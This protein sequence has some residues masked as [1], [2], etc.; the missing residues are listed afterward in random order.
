MPR[1]ALFV[2]APLAFGALALGSL[3]FAACRPATPDAPAATSSTASPSAQAPRLRHDA[4]LDSLFGGVPGT[5]VVLDPARA[6]TLR[7]DA[8]RARTRRIP[9]STHKIVHTLIAL[10]TGV[11]P[12]TALAIR[13]DAARDPAEPWWPA[14]WAQDQTLGTAFRASAVWYFRELARRIGRDRSQAWLDT[15]GYGSRR[16]GARADRYWLDGSLTI[17]ADEQVGFLDRLWS[18]RLPVDARSFAAV[19]AFMRLDARG[20]AVLYGKT[21]TGPDA[22]GEVG[23]LVGVVE[24][25]GARYPYALRLEARPEETVGSRE[26]RVARAAVLLRAAGVWP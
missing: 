15:L 22:G 16:I 18:G 1:P 19:R 13:Y 25:G 23:W 5:F 14:T 17:S 26:E 12:D 9:A 2:L 8:A 7:H 20:E 24:R 10:E 3:T 11:A 4:N 6:D 21:G